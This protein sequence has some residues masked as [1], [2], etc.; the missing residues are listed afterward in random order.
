MCFWSNVGIASEKWAD[1]PKLG[2]A[3]KPMM[4]RQIRPFVVEVSC[5]QKK[6]PNKIK[7]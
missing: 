3:F 4:R 5:I 1:E 7:L 6:F 2:W